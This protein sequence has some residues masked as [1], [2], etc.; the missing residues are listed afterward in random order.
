MQ[1]RS[2][3]LKIE[4]PPGFQLNDNRRNVKREMDF[5]GERRGND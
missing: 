4:I 3:Q 2:S 5:A 1:S